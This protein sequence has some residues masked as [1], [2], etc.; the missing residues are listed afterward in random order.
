MLA[1]LIDD[2]LCGGKHFLGGV[3]RA[4]GYFEFMQAASE[5]STKI[6][7][8]LPSTLSVLE[9]CLRQSILMS[10]VPA[11]VFDANF[12]GTMASAVDEHASNLGISLS[13]E[14]RRA[15]VTLCINARKLMGVNSAAARRDSWTIGDVRSLPGEYQRLLDGQGGRCIWCGVEMN[16]VG[17]YATLEHLAPKHIGDDLEDGSNW[18][19]AC[20]S[21]N[22]GKG[23]SFAWAAHPW[24]HDYFSRTDFANVNSIGLPQRF[25]VLRRT[26]RCDGC[27]REPKSVELH[28]YKLVPTGLPIPALCSASCSYCLSA[29]GLTPIAPRWAAK[30]T[31]RVVPIP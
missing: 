5:W 16:A 6:G 31:L 28:V 21:C 12:E 23:E 4:T 1:T 13:H 17:V 8:S 14:Q 7:R 15:V 24:A 3:H 30:E 9:P 2:I 19:I 20:Q 29:R 25:A 10:L 27:N 22:A 26:G 18:A 11:A